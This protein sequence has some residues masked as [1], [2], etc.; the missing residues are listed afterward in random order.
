[1][2]K[3]PNRRAKINP[4]ILINQQPEGKEQ[5]HSADFYLEKSVQEVKSA[6]Q[7]LRI[8]RSNGRNKSSEKETTCL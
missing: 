1:M 4:D 7:C 8:W 3:Q 2:S 6:L 5:P